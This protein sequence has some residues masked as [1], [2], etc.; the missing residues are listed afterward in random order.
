M[1]I[2][3]KKIKNKEYCYFV[4]NKWKK[5]RG[6]HQKVKE[7]LG[8][9]LRMNCKENNFFDFYKIKDLNIFLKKK[10][11]KAL[12]FDILKWQ[13]SNLGFKKDNDELKK[14]DLTFN[15]KVMTLKKN[16][17]KIVIRNNEGYLCSQTIKSIIQFEKTGDIEKDSVA[18]ARAFV[19]AGLNIP[20]EVFIAFFEKIE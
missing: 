3:V 7:Y 6:T 12:L 8:P 19:D 13:L 5:N 18:L 16:N 20:K 9:L 17:K 15:K 2:R 1:F 11:K 10:D 4:Q 14:N